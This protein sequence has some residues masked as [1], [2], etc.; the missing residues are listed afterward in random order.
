MSPD[1]YWD[2][3]RS[4]GSLNRNI[5][6]IS[7]FWPSQYGGRKA[8]QPLEEKVVDPPFPL[9]NLPYVGQ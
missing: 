9:C 3:K 2:D 5:I 4:G 6:G 7:Y 8:S 1:K